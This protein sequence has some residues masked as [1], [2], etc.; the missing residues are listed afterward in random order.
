[1]YETILVPTDGS[2]AARRAATEAF[3][4]AAETGATVHLVY[5]VDEGATSVLFGGARLS[6]VLETLTEEGEEAVAALEAEADERGV[7]A[8]GDVVRGVSVAE[9]IDDYAERV[10]ADLV[11]MSSHGRHGVEHVL[12]STTERTLARAAVPVLVVP[13]P[14]AE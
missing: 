8:V 2:E 3:D 7:D 13:R 4:I 14:G 9:A 6:D 1:M 10:E 5:V 11:V 12:G